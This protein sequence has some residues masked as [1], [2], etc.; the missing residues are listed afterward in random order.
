MRFFLL[1]ALLLLL[2]SVPGPARA[3]PRMD[4]AVRGALACLKA[5]P[6][7][8]RTRAELRKA[9]FTLE[10][11]Y[12]GRFVQF[13]SV[14]NARAVVATVGAAKLRR[15]VVGADNVTDQQGIALAR[16]IARRQLTRGMGE[17]PKKHLKSPDPAR[18]IVYG[19]AGRDGKGR[20]WVIY[21]ASRKTWAD[22][23]VSPLVFMDPVPPQKTPKQ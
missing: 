12:A 8:A 14:P 16:Q 2:P 11:G 1:L 23:F 21:V 22:F 15:C 20:L 18:R 4:D 3:D 6:S 19:I 9:G 17:V 13:Y 5:F 7:K 10:D